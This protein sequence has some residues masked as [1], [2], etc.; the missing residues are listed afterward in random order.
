MSSFS[1]SDHCTYFHFLVMM[2]MVV[3]FI[4][5]HHPHHRHHHQAVQKSECRQPPVSLVDIGPSFLSAAPAQLSD[6]V[7][8]SWHLDNDDHDDNHDVDDHEHLDVD[9]DDNGFGQKIICALDASFKIYISRASALIIRLMLLTSFQNVDI[10]MEYCSRN[11]FV[12]GMGTNNL[13]PN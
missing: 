12:I 6:Y 1:K 7:I 11:N 9:D 3:F 10:S 4:H 5:H 13:N 2:M 8:H